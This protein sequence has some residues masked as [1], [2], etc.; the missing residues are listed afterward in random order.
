MACNCKNEGSKP[1]KIPPFLKPVVYFLTTVLGIVVVP[2]L[3]AGVIIFI[4]PYIIYVMLAR[5]VFNKNIDIN[6][7]KMK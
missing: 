4:T 1:L 3:V 5:H 7:L 6:F 2:L